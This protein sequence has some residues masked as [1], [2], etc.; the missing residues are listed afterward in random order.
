MVLTSPIRLSCSNRPTM[1]P[2]PTVLRK[3]EGSSS[4]DL[5][6]TESNNIIKQG[7]QHGGVDIS[8]RNPKHMNYN[9]RG[10]EDD[11]VLEFCCG[12]VR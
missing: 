7:Q 1:P 10:D 2:H 3:G 4:D 8:K 6:L 11:D 9:D 5:S 12:R